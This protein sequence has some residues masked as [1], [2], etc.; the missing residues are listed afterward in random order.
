MKFSSKGLFIAS[1]PIIL[2]VGK[3]DVNVNVVDGLKYFASNSHTAASSKQEE[4]QQEQHQ[5][6]QL[7]QRNHEEFSFW[8]DLQ[9]DL[10]SFP[11]LLP[12]GT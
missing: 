2:V 3:N 1:L 9:E 11:P 12:T 8:R 5:P 6:Q 7:A 10:T 4:E